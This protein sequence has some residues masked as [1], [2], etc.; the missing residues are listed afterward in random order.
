MAKPE[1]ERKKQRAV[2]FCFACASWVQIGQQC[3]VQ[4]AEQ[5]LAEAKG[6]TNG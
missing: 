5:E 6:G 1:V 3:Q 2:R 4:Q